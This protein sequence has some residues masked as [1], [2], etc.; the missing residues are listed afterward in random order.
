M[1]STLQGFVQVLTS[2]FGMGTHGYQMVVIFAY[3]GG[4]IGEQTRRELSYRTGSGS[5]V[6][7]NLVQPVIGARPNVDDEEHAYEEDEEIL[8][9][10][11]PVRARSSGH[12]FIA[13][14]R[15]RR[16]SRDRVDLFDSYRQLPDEP[17]EVRS[18]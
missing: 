17:D 15:H 7:V 2:S 8:R 14:R 16:R 13:A 6:G 3:I 11:R 12:P 4:L 10:R 1:L 9:S 18:R 5:S